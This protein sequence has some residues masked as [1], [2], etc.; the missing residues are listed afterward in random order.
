VAARHAIGNHQDFKADRNGNF[1]RVIRGPKW[2]KERS[3]GLNGAK[4]RRTTDGFCPAGTTGL[5]QGF[6]PGNRHPDRH[7]LKGRQIQRTNNVKAESI[8]GRLDCAFNFRAAIS[9]RF[10]LSASR[11]FRANSFILRFPGLKPWAESYS[12]F[13]ANS[14]DHEVRRGRLTYLA[15]ATFY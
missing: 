12:P 9:A 5:S 8:V 2:P 15:N 1:R 3:P 13:G 7:A 11:P 10:I 6:N 4:L 14:A